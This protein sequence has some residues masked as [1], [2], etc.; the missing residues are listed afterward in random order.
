MYK[1]YVIVMKKKNHRMKKIEIFIKVQK[2]EQKISK[3]CSITF[4]LYLIDKIIDFT[5]ELS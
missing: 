1:H 2:K 5:K 4:Y 3:C